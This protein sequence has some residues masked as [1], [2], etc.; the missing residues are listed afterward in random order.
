MSKSSSNTNINS[1]VNTNINPVV[2]TN[3]NP[4]FNTNI[5]QAT[6]GQDQRLV[7]AQVKMTNMLY[8]FDKICKKYNIN[9]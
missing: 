3:I 8:E 9:Y 5:N 1:V 7:I 6:A 2:N 4:V